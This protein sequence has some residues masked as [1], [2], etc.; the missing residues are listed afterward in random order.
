MF[1]RVASAMSWRTASTMVGGSRTT[2]VTSL[3]RTVHRPLAPLQASR[4]HLV[5]TRLFASTTNVTRVWPRLSPSPSSVPLVSKISPLIITRSL[6]SDAKQGAESA[7]KAKKVVVIGDAFVAK[8]P[9]ATTWKNHRSTGIVLFV[10]RRL[11]LE[12]HH[13]QS[14]SLP[15]APS[16]SQYGRVQLIRDRCVSC[17]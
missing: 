10:D 4:A 17:A 6:A 14:P 2:T 3:M 16:T 13:K 5:R 9:W 8:K 15:S 1:S 12:G 11:K 7:V